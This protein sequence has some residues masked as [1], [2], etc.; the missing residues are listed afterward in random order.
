V[1]SL[2]QLTLHTYL[3]WSAVS[4]LFLLYTSTCKP[5]CLTL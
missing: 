3:F 2:A 4:L 1:S 5:D